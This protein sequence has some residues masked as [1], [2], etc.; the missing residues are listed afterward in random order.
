MT[1]AGLERKID[2]HAYME[3]VAELI[4]EETKV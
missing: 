4:A 2:V 3:R 1:A